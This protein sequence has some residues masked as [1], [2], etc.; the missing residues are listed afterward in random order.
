MEIKREIVSTPF[1]NMF[2]LPVSNGVY[3]ETGHINDANSCYP[4]TVN[5]VDYYC[6]ANIKREN[7]VTAVTHVYMSRNFK[8]ATYA[9]KKKVIAELAKVADKWIK[10]NA[11]KIRLATLDSMRMNAA[12]HEGAV[13]RAQEKL[14]AEK[15]E[16]N[17]AYLKY[18]ALYFEIHHEY[19]TD[20]EGN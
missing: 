3:M 19:P 8:D 9:A 1:G 17:E 16:F 14:D 5:T 7:G 13:R 11:E 12:S 6:T 4:I 15:K 18:E 10:E 2:I 20:L